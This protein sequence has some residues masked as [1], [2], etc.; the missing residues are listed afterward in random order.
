VR[1]IDFGCVR[2]KPSKAVAA[3]G[4]IAT[5]LSSPL[6]SRGDPRDKL[7]G[8]TATGRSAISTFNEAIE[9][10]GV[11][12]AFE[13]R[14]GYL[15]SVLK[16]FRIST[17]SQ[18]VVF[19]QAS[20]QANLIN[21][22]NPRAVYF[23]DD[24]AVGWV[25]GS[26][27][28]EVAAFDPERGIA[29]YRLEQTANEKPRFRRD[30][31]CLACHQSERTTGVPGLFVL[32]TP[33]IRDGSGFLSDHRTPFTERW[34][35]WY[36]TG[37]S[38]RFRHLGNRTGQGWL[39]SLYDQFDT[40][41]YLTEY[42][43]V[44]ALMTL[45]HQ[46][47]ATNLITRL[48]WEMRTEK[49]GQRLQEAVNALVD[50]LLFVDE[51]P[52]P[53]RIIGTSG[54]REKFEALGPADRRGRS[55]RQFD[56]RRRMMLYPCS[57]MIYSQAFDALPSTARQSVYARLWYILAGRSEQGKYAR[58]PP[59]EREAVIEILR[60]TKRDLPRYWGAPVYPRDSAT[61]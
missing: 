24:I 26:S 44:V 32:S 25:R 42:S 43:D 21:Q 53:S 59:T 56:L 58:V 11:T 46:T 6:P 57:Y 35:G 61:Y 1:V 33:S 51:A 36:V 17:E 45:E 48:A 4:F 27:S 12:P 50:Y 41:G 23:N 34:G 22:E 47:K 40:S 49:S 29:F 19:S 8:S 13:P 2:I 55:L 9:T 31:S 30:D 3:I 10:G 5:C 39:Q 20:F 14:S 60:D 18:I 16:Y 15:R 7:G 38:G 28:I 52:L 54:F 37:L